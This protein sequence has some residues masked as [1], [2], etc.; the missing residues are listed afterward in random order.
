MLDTCVLY[1]QSLCDTLLRMADGE[2]FEL[3][4]SQRIL[5]ELE[6]NL[7][8]RESV[9]AE[10]AAR[11]RQAMTLTFD[12]AEVDPDAIDRLEPKMDNDPKDR[13]STGST[14]NGSQTATPHR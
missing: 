8:V 1:P 9:G 10:G 14:D 4:W 7:A 3:R 13:T 5:D 6:R 12:G 11:R 2:F